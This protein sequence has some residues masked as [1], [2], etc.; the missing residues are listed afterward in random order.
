MRTAKISPAASNIRVA[1]RVRPPLP[2]EI[3][4]GVF[5]SCLA[6][7]PSQKDIYITSDERPV[8]VPDGGAALPFGLMQ[9]NFDFIGSQDVT[10]E[11][12]YENCCRDIVSDVGR[13]M[14]GTVFAYGQTGTGKTHTM[15]GAPRH[16]VYRI[17][18]I[19]NSSH[20]IQ[21][22]SCV[23][24]TPTSPCRTYYYFEF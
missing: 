1:V 23:G 19:L 17:I 8:F 20:I 21:N 15:L 4:D 18:I 2:R 22:Y 9:F 12:F 6:V 3:V 5:D 14:N 11:E 16:K 7:P 10:T 24:G 13:G